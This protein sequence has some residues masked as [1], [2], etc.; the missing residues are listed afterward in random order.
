MI[1]DDITVTITGVH[2]TQVRIGIQAPRD[3]A[4]NREEIHERI[5]LA[6]AGLASGNR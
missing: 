2:G 5:E 4:V 3:V 1:G 6:K